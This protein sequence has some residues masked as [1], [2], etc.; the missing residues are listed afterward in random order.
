MVTLTRPLH[1]KPG[2]LHRESEDIHHRSLP[3]RLALSVAAIYDLLSG[4]G[5]TE[6]DHITREMAVARPVFLIQTQGYS[7]Y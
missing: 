6:R 3:V 4:K 7:R 5:M 1:G 2:L